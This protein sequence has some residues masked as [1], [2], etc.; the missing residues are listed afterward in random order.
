MQ[1]DPHAWHKRPDAV[2]VRLTA[3]L[4]VVTADVVVGLQPKSLRP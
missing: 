1:V 4:T 3:V 2:T